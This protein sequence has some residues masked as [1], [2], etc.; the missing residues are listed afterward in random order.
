MRKAIGRLLDAVD[1]TVQ[2]AKEVEQARKDLERETGRLRGL[3]LVGEG[4]GES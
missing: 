4:G 2:A 1:R 3:R